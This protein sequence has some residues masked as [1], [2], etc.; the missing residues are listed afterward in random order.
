M[1]RRDMNRNSSGWEGFMIRSKGNRSEMED[2]T[3]TPISIT[4]IMLR[5]NGFR[6]NR[7]ILLS[8]P[9]STLSSTSNSSSSS[10]EEEGTPCPKNSGKNNS[11]RKSQN[12]RVRWVDG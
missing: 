4:R 3:T 10:S 8:S 2:I 5:E 7:G 9:S 6:N 11:G 1:R 12:K